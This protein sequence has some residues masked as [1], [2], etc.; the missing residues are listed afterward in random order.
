MHRLSLAF[1]IFL[2]PFLQAFKRLFLSDRSQANETSKLVAARQEI[3]QLP[4]KPSTSGQDSFHGSQFLYL[5][6]TGFAPAVDAMPVW[7]FSTTQKELVR[8]N[9]RLVLWN[10]E[11]RQHLG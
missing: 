3:P 10:N 8:P 7:V 4:S 2:L 11:P 6:E 5:E 1:V 9:S